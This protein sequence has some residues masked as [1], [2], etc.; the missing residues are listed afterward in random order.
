M[1]GDPPRLETRP[2]GARPRNGGAGRTGG[3]PG[4]DGRYG[5]SRP[6]RSQGRGQRWGVK[7]GMFIL[8]QE[9]RQGTGRQEARCYSLG[10]RGRGQ[11]EWERR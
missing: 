5:G 1:W 2:S 8:V 10:Q 9:R 3:N 4:W 7:V 6:R 11:R